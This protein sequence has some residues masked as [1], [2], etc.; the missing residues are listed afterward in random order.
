MK[1][2][3]VRIQN[4]R[5][6]LHA[7]ELLLDGNI[8]ILIGPNGGGK[9]N[10]LDTITTFLRR[11]LLSSWVYRRTPSESRPDQIQVTGNDVINNTPFEPHFSGSAL[12]QEVEFEVEVTL[13][14]IVNMA[15]IQADAARLAVVAELNGF[16]TNLRQALSWDLLSIL[17][18]DRFTYRISQ[19]SLQPPSSEAARLFHG[20]LTL[21]EADGILRECEGEARLSTPMLSLPVNR[22]AR[23]KMP[24]W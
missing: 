2:R 19:N 3:R 15:K 20:Y 24:A 6:F 8:S 23:S 10:L 9:T 14:D 13:T 11:H 17:V 18:K 22:S 7:E 16:N 21:F 4:I 12:P 5:S 1:L